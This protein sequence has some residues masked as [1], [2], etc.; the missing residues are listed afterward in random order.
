AAVQLHRDKPAG[1][2]AQARTAIACD[3]LA[4]DA[5][6]WQPADQ[7][8]GNLR[9]L[10]AGSSC[11]YH[12]LV[13]EAPHGHEPVPLLVGELLAHSEEVRAERRSETAL[14]HAHGCAPFLRPSRGGMS[15]SRNFSTTGASN[16]GLAMSSR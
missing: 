7:C 15:R 9:S 11:R 3:V 13:H 1:H 5:E 6:L 2:R 10:P 8:P 14:C 16:D 4:D 12:I